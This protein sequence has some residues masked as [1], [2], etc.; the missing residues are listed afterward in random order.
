MSTAVLP[1]AAVLA[2]AAASAAAVATADIN[3]CV[4]GSGA[5]VSDVVSVVAEAASVWSD[6]A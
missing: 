5:A 6:W 2:S 1:P 3:A 4:L